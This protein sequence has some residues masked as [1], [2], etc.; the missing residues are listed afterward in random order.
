ME[1]R[2]LD[3]LFLLSRHFLRTGNRKYRRSIVSRLSKGNRLSIITGQRG[4]GKTT[5][6]IQALN[7]AASGKEL[8]REY[9]YVQT[10]HFSV[11][12]LKIY[13]IARFFHE[14]GGK[15]LC[16]D[17]IHKYPDWSRELKSIHDTF[18]G[19]TVIATGSSALHIFKGSH[20]LSRR[21]IVFPLAGFS[22]REY[23]ECKFDIALSALDLPTL[24]SSHEESALSIIKSVENKGEKILRLFGEY[25]ECGFYPFYQEFND[26][27]LF[28]S[29]LERNI[30]TTIENDLLALHPALTG[31]S[32]RKIKKLLSFIAA[33]VPFTPEMSRLK[34]ICDIGD[35]R[36]LKT[37]LSYLSDGG[38]ISMISSAGTKM[39]VLEKPEKIYLDNSNQLHAL[40]PLDCNIGTVRETFF[41]SMLKPYHEISI[42]ARGDFLVN[43]EWTFEVGG[44]NKGFGQIKNIKKSFRAIDDIEKGINSTIPLWMFGFLY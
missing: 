27:D 44:K 34:K 22:F 20:D 1:L 37:Y 15:M 8:S 35:E 26:S 40:R 7:N 28:Y 25:L 19:L 17:E 4:V 3:E 29:A 2:M 12:N 9:L 32:I 24:L 13:E 39:N 38:I 23:L 16:F 43:D 33:S 18:H 10:D 36:T 6:L 31:T 14:H 11:G 5:A 21:A 42:P 30:H 41:V